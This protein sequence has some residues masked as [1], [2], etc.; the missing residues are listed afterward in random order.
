MSGGGGNPPFALE[1]AFT[2]RVR[3]TRFCRL[4][5]LPL[6]ADSYGDVANDSRVLFPRLLVRNTTSASGVMLVEVGLILFLDGRTRELMARC[7]HGG[8]AG[9]RR[10]ETPPRRAI[11]MRGKTAPPL[12]QTAPRKNARFGRAAARG[13]ENA[14]A[15][16]PGA[17]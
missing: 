12:R 17:I 15:A 6:T 11:W 10:L 13:A 1:N 7:R 5:G 14:R 8:S 2:D 9:I 3:P 4:R 16:R